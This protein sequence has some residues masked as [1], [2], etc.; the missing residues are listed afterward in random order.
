[1]APGSVPC[2]C[3][4]RG[5]LRPPTVPGFGPC[6]QSRGFGAGAQGRQGCGESPRG[7]QAGGV[8]EAREQAVRGGLGDAGITGAQNTGH[9]LAPTLS[10][11]HV[12]GWRRW[13]LSPHPANSLHP[14]NV[15]RLVGEPA[16]SVTAFLI[17]E[18]GSQKV[19]D[20]L[21]QEAT[22]QERRWSEVL[23]LTA[24]RPVGAASGHRRPGRRA[25]GS[26]EHQRGLPP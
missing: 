8:R 23:Q 25:A 22:L 6:V 12:L 20:W 14:C 17:R 9:H 16:P 5:C 15:P 13:S 24:P 7:S 3:S 1:M 10:P 26:W 19:E 21:L 18:L 11:V 4:S 2:T